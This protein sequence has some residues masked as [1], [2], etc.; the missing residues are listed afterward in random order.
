[1]K[2]EHQ[3]QVTQEVHYDIFVKPHTQTNNPYTL[4]A[5]ESHHIRKEG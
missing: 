2:Q 4:V 3:I 5:R 1:M